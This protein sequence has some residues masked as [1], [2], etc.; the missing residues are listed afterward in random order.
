MED[1]QQEHKIDYSVV[2]PVFNGSKSI[3]ELYERLV[4]YFHSTQYSFEI[5]FVDDRS[6]DDSWN[7]ISRI[8]QSNPSIVKGIR[9][10]RNY[11]QHLA[12]CS[13]IKI[14]SGSFIITI[15]D[16]LEVDPFQIQLLIDRQIKSKSLLVYGVFNNT[17]RNIFRK[18]LKNIYAII[19]RLIEG[20]R[21][22]KGSSFR[23]IQSDLAKT[24]EQSATKFIFLDEVFLWYTD[25]ISYENV[26]HFASKRGCSN[27][28]NWNLIKITKDLM[29]YSSFF[30][31]KIVKYV[32]LIFSS[33]NFIIATF[34]LYRKFNNGID[35][36][37][38]ASIVIS[39]LFS[40]GIIIFVLGVIGDY[41]SKMYSVLNRPPLYYVDEII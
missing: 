38:Y 5:I 32:G 35:I 6:K 37:G 9:L 39:V 16:D 40:T 19:A 24:I 30:P 17:K 31:L 21:I 33:V 27:Y 2:I 25:S 15:D 20:S 4:S 23:L 26:N 13:G 8:K 18:L 36:P 10:S 7:I 3:L 29:L 12:T 34:Y 14:S 28:S 1:L 22:K 41:L 11:G